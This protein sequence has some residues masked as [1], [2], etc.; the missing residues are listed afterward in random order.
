MKKRKIEDEICQG[1][2]HWRYQQNE[3]KQ[4]WL[5]TEGKKKE[6]NIKRRKQ[7]TII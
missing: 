4:N 2:M 5:A 1:N 3:K 7:L 6:R